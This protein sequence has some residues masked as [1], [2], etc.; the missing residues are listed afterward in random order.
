MQN[1]KLLAVQ[2]IASDSP[3]SILLT[4]DSPLLQFEGLHISHLDSILPHVTLN[5]AQQPLRPRTFFVGPSQCDTYHHTTYTAFDY[6][7]HM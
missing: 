1:E 7:T 2:K 6:I 3:L 5:T 4:F